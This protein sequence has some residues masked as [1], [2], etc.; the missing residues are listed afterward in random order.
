MYT[1]NNDEIVSTYC[2]IASNNKTNKN[3]SIEFVSPV[4]KVAEKGSF[5]SH[6]KDFKCKLF[7]FLCVLR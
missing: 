6:L 7:I 5:S 1:V 3:G 4:G 2:K